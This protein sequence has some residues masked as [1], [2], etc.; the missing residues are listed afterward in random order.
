MNGYRNSFRNNG[1]K[2][3]HST[4]SY[5][6][7]RQKHENPEHSAKSLCQP[8]AQARATIRESFD[9]TIK[10]FFIRPRL[11][12]GLKDR[13]FSWKTAPARMEDVSKMQLQNLRVGLTIFCD[14]VANC[15]TSKWIQEFK[16]QHSSEESQKLDE[17]SVR[18]PQKHDGNRRALR[19]SA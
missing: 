14:R 17:S 16:I 12:V 15:V 8:D 1:F 2:I 9:A 4:R 11:R 18:F 13:K 7:G 3:Q 6:V 19:W 5:A 10:P